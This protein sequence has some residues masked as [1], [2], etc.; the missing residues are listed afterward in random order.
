MHWFDAGINCFDKRMP[1]QPTLSEAVEC[2]VSKMCVIATHQQDWQLCIDA[3]TTNSDSLFCTIGVHPHYADNVTGQWD[4]ELAT[5]LDNPCVVAVGEC[6]LDFN[7]MF[8]T[9]E[10]QIMVFERQ[11]EIAVEHQLPVYLHE[12]DAFE[13]QYAI[14]SKYANQLKSGL[15]HCFTQ[16]LEQ[17]QAYLSLGF[18]IGI[19]GWVCDPKRGQALR[20]A[21]SHLPL[22]KIILET[23]A[24][25][26]FPKTVKPRQSNNHPKYLPDI[27]NTV[28]QIVG[29]EPVALAS[30]TF[31]NTCTLFGLSEQG[32]KHVS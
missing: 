9:R 27:A 15:V 25:Y 24:P 23:D 13:Q 16:S 10:N 29:I 2:G 1:L 3:A 26:L 11:L 20:D 30:Q 7:R 31:L 8:S 19:T 22:D 4:L 32:V 12:R 5:C 14:L 18:Y 17:M 21:V 28:A 6:G